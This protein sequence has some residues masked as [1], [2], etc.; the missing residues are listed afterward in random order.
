MTAIGLLYA[1]RQAGVSVPQDVA[2]VGFDDIPFASYV[3][4]SLSSVAQP[5]P[6]MG[7]QATEMILALMSSEDPAGADVTNVTV[8]GRLVV[9]ES[10][11]AMV[12][13]SKYRL[14]GTKVEVDR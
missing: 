9:R 8:Q 12:R 7:K 1:A 3:Q 13:S 14:V 6:E 10:S 11:G 5:K 4:P 2:V